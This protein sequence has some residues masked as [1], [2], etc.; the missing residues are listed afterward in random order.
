MIDILEVVK[1]IKEPESRNAIKNVLYYFQHNETRDMLKKEIMKS[2]KNE[3]DTNNRRKDILKS[4]LGV[5]L[6]AEK[7][8][9]DKD[10]LISLF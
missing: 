8:L 6:A 1:Y 2:L 9:N 10:T 5:C 3:K 4:I 7:H